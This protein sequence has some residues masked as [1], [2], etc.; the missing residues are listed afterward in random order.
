MWRYFISIIF[1]ATSVV[2]KL[3]AQDTITYPMKLRVG[4]DLF[5]ASK[6]FYEND[7]LD[8]EAFFSA[9]LNEKS[10]AI[11]FAGVSDYVYPRYRDATFLKYNLNVRGVYAKMGLD[12]NMLH[13][14][15]AAGKYFAGVGFRYGISNY[16]FDVSEINFENYWGRYTTS[17][18]KKNTM[19]HFFEVALS[20]RVAVF[21]NVSFGWSA[22]L[23]KMISAGVAGD[24]RSVYVPGYGDTSKSFGFSI[25]YSI[26]L[27]IPYKDKRVIVYPQFIETD[28]D[29]FDNNIDNNNNNY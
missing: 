23:K 28:D 13:T 24:M 8:I 26:I 27:N 11:F 7:M 9:D 10:S 1:V 25:N 16:S 5:G 20:T 22:N 14:K 12:Y 2:C 15:K 17:I 19:A 6:I 18:P 21:R 29:F 3:Q 4:F